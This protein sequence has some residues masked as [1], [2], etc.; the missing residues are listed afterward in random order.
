MMPPGVDDGRL[1][2]SWW[3]TRAPGG[4]NGVRRERVGHVRPGPGARRVRRGSRH[5]LI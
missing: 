3:S 4:A 5:R 2:I 1:G